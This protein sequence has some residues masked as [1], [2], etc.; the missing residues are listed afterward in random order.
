[1]TKTVNKI[2]ETYNFITLEL[3]KYKISKL[4]LFSVTKFYVSII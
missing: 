4:V 1:M 2:V 3:K